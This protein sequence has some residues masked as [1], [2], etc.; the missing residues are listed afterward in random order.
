MDHAL[1]TS[2]HAAQPEPAS[3]VTQQA[4]LLNPASNLQ[5]KIDPPTKDDEPPLRLVAGKKRAATA[6]SRGVANLTPEQLAKKRANDR[7]AQRA[8]RKRTK[9]QI[10]ALQ[11]R[12][13][14]LTSQQPYQD[15]QEAQRQKEMIQ[16]ENEEIRRRLGSVMAI[17]HPI[18]SPTNLATN[19]GLPVDTSGT[20]NESSRPSDRLGV[21][22]SQLDS[23]VHS[24]APQ[25][26]TSSQRRAS[27]SHTQEHCLRTPASL[28]SLPSG[29]TYTGSPRRG[30]SPSPSLSGPMQGLRPNWPPTTAAAAA[31][32]NFT[33]QALPK[34]NAFDFQKRNLVHGLEFS[35]SGERLGLNFLIDSSRQGSKVHELRPSA[36]SP[37][38]EGQLRYQHQV[39][40][41]STNIFD[42]TMP[43]FVIPIRNA[44]PTCPLDC[45]LL[46]FL[47]SRQ[48]EA[49][50]GVSKGHLV[51]PPYPSV[52]SLL[53]PEKSDNSHPLSK[54]F[55]DI[56]SKF[57]DI[58]DLPEKVAVVYV[59]FLLMRW[60]IYPT[61]ENYDRL[62]EWITP[63]VSQLVTPHP[64]WMDYLPWPR[65][66]DRM[67]ACH[68]DYDFS[69]WFIPYTTTLSINWPYSDSDAL[70]AIPNSEEY[71][72]NPVF[73][74]HLR[75]LNNWSLGPAFA[76]HYPDLVDTCRIKT[77]P[78]DTST[79]GA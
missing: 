36:P 16:A 17:L 24:P 78:W 47:R 41:T 25:S 20:S 75:N 11:Q 10:D 15:L 21:W 46:N 37:S 74:S 18:L 29:T 54:V 6:T 55:T 2:P 53:N 31:A 50:E 19:N 27:V 56:I 58:R 40:V 8:I 28:E 57:P 67:I 68:T 13:Q 62:P 73:E 26:D 65:M 42:T 44:E 39:Q 43:P 7:E 71:V 48:R 60:Q 5:P 3:T 72:I 23:V 51:G 77:D 76:K 34:C 38:H 22:A 64:P 66:R 59:M 33:E 45:I 4:P 49:A 69:N 14:E 35:G 32:T 63:R 70:I 30:Q 1:H 79:N 61:R 9:A 52:S 12:V